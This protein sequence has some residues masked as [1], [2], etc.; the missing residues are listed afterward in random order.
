[1]RGRVVG[2]QKFNAE[3]IETVF[4][5]EWL[6]ITLVIELDREFAILFVERV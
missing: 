5:Y 1:M 3:T 4:V 6:P 2:I